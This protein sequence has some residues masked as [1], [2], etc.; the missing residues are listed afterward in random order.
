MTTLI[1][2]YDLK[3]GGATP[4]GAINR[5]IN[6]KLAE[7]ISIKDFG[8]QCDGVTDDTAAVQAAINYC[9]TFDQWPALLI[10]GQTLLTDYY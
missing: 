6:E 5:P 4:T 2:K 7:W 9:A 8:A 3:D 1:P 10:P